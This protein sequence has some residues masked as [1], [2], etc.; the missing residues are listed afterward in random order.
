MAFRPTFSRASAA[1]PGSADV[2]DLIQKMSALGM[3]E[4]DLV[5]QVVV[6]RIKKQTLDEQLLI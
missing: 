2:A 4:A 6:K 3:D 1:A 5:A